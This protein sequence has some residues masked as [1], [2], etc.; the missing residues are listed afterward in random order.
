MKKNNAE[1]MESIMVQ[2]TEE[3]TPIAFNRKVKELLDQGAFESEEDA[4]AWVYQNPIE[5]ELYYSIDCG[6]FGVESDAIEN[7]ADIY[8]PYTAEMLEDFDED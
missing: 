4:K 8:D 7:G 5:L 2:L 3:K 1:E 6:L